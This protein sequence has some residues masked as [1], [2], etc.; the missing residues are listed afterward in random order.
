MKQT[1]K[2]TGVFSPTSQRVIVIMRK[3]DEEPTSA[4]VV[5]YDRLPDIYRDNLFTMLKSEESS[6]TNDFYT[7]LDNRSFGDGQPILGTLHKLGHVKKVL[8]KDVVLSLPDNQ[9]LNLADFNAY[10]DGIEPTIEEKMTEIMVQPTPE[11]DLTKKELAK[12]LLAEAKV[13]DKQA[14]EKKEQAYVL[15][16]T[17]RPTKGRPKDTIDEKRKK[18]MERNRIRRER[19]ASAKVEA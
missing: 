7:I 11:K 3:L 14:D 10:M 1:P 16:P 17:L 18:R 5:E 2:H 15:V 12:Q 19:Y 6:K 9:T 8:V 4:L 13:L